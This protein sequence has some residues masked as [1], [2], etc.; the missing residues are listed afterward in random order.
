MHKTIKVK[1][2]KH[3]TV[4]PVNFLKELLYHNKY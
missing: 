1:Y 2:V 3:K 4:N